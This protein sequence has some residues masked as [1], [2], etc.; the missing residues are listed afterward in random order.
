MSSGKGACSDVACLAVFIYI[1]HDNIPWYSVA[2][3]TV[4]F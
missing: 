1:L 2:M 4:P 3:E